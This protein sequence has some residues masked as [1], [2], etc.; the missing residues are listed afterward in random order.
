MIGYWRHFKSFILSISATQLCPILDH[1]FCFFN[2]LYPWGLENGL[3][4]SWVWFRA[5]KWMG[6]TPTC[7][8]KMFWSACPRKR[9]TSL[10]SCC[11]TSG[12]LNNHKNGHPKGGH[13]NSQPAKFKIQKSTCVPRGLTF[14]QQW[15]Y[16]ISLMPMSAS[17][18]INPSSERLHNKKSH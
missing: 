9:T 13:L 11:R 18:N 4:R 17:R 15:S 1:F 12:S 7:T 5:P 10:T 16:A 14:G 3:Q 2:P 8:S 6:M